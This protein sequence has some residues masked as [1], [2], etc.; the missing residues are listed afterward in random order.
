MPPAPDLFGDEGQERREEALQCR[1]GERERGERGPRR[2]IQCVAVGADLHEF[3]VVV[4]ERPEERL[5]AFECPGVVVGV[6]G[7]RRLGDQLSEHGQQV[8]VEGLGDVARR[9][10]AVLEAPEHELGRVEDLDGETASHLHLGVVDR[11][12]R[13]G[14]ARGRPVAQRVGAVQLEQRFGRHDVALGLAHLLAVGVENPTRDHRVLPRQG[15][16]LEV[17]A[18]DRREEPRADDV[19]GLG[20]KVHRKDALEEF[21]TPVTRDFGGQ[22]TRR[23]GVHDVGV[24]DEAVRLVALVA[25]VTRRGLA[26]RVDRQ[27][28]HLREQGR[29]VE[30]PSVGVE[31]VPHR[32]RHAEEPLARDV[33]VEVEPLD[34]GPVAVSHEVGVPVEL[35]AAREQLGAVHQ[36]RD[37]P[38]A[39]GH[40][41]QGSFAPLVELDRMSDGAQFADQFA[42]LAQRV[43]HQGADLVDGVPLDLGVERVRRLGVTRLELLAREIGGQESSVASDERACRQVQFAPPDHVGR[44]AEGA[45][46]RDARTLLGVGQFVRDDRHLDVKERR[47]DVGAEERLVALVV[48]VRDERDAARQQLGPRRVD[49]DGATR[50]GL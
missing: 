28:G 49:L 18:H 17:T 38:L 19:V 43:D 4:T 34:P 26:R 45:D 16:V 44:V 46:H 5:G 25:L 10:L 1:E 21:R 32:E 37:E 22:R 23:P 27:R 14:S 12:V 15:V 40:D 39:R 7:D 35:L 13:A 20:A 30:H 47:D 24:A 36:R 33:P 31:R 2:R 9:V 11:G 41:L 50:V 29:V 42:A 3:D 8:P 6:K 48:G